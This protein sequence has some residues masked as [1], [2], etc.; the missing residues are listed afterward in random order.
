MDPGL[1]ATM[2]GNPDVTPI[3]AEARQLVNQALAR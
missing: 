2:A 3:A 1:M